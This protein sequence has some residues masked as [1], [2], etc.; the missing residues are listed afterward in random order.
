MK[1][2]IRK[3]TRKTLFSRFKINLS[4]SLANFTIR[5]PQRMGNPPLNI[6]L[7]NELEMML[8]GITL[9]VIIFIC[10]NTSY[11]VYKSKKLD[12]NIIKLN[13]NVLYAII[14]YTPIG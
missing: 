1:N 11:K 4:R 13:L 6:K 5:R 9:I 10:P 14:L 3:L 2:K 8:Y 12:F 7:A